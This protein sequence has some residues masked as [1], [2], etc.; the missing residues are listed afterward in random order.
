MRRFNAIIRFPLPTEDERRAIW[1][2]ALPDRA[3]RDHLAE[4][5]ARFELSGGNIINVVQFAAIE[6]IAAGC[7]TIR[8][9]DAVKGIRREVEKEG[10]RIP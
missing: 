5:L 9:G 1:Q 6:A 8:L 3:G 2:R 4:Q 7:E 10:G